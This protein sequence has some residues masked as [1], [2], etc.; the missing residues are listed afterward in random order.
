MYMKI[1]SI[2]NLHIYLSYLLFIVSLSTIAFYA[3]NFGNEYWSIFVFLFGWLGIFIGAFQWYANIFYLIA[4]NEKDNIKSSIIFASIG[5]LIALSFCILKPPI[6][7]GGPYQPIVGFGI[8]YGFWL[9]SMS[10]FLFGQILLLFKVRLLH[11]NYY[12]LFFTFFFIAII[13]FE[14]F[15][16]ENS[17]YQ[18]DKKQSSIFEQY[19]KQSEM[20]IFHKANNVEGIYFSNDK[21]SLKFNKNFGFELS[22][23]QGIG[24]VNLGYIKHY[25]YMQNGK[26]YKAFADSEKNYEIKEINITSPKSTILVAIESKTYEK[27]GIHTQNII[28][29]DIKKNYMLGK[30]FVVVKMQ[31][32]HFKYCPEQGFAT[33]TFIK[34]V[35]NLKENSYKNYRYH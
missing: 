27:Y 20:K 19:C 17:P 7:F 3:N 29:K 15:Y 12:L 13:G 28:I 4:L 2:E 18:F 33:A 16:S 22:A 21:G 8:G 25:E 6:T 5:L 24:L 23:N 9:V 30:A 14:Y 35:L 10:V 32:S 34:D 1:L 26:Y 31:G 11:K